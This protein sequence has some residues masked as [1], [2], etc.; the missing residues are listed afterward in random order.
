[1][2]KVLV[3]CKGTTRD[4]IGTWAKGRSVIMTC[5]PKGQNREQ[6]VTRIE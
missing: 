1:M 5:R 3:G 6:V 4:T 2:T